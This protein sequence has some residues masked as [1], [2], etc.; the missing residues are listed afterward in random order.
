MV[1]IPKRLYWYRLN[2]ESITGVYTYKKLDEANIING[3]SHA[4]LRALI[5]SSSPVASPQLQEY[6]EARAVYYAHGALWRIYCANMSSR[7]QDFVSVSKKLI[8]DH[9]SKLL[10]DKQTYDFKLRCI[11]GICRYCF[12]I[13]IIAVKMSAFF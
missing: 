13:W 6:L 7:Y 8:H 12:P 2:E 1:I 10:R 4:T 3:I 11:I 5:A 9:I